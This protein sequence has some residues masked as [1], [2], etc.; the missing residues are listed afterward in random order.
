MCNKKK[1][2]EEVE[3]R[4]QSSEANMYDREML[5][6]VE[7]WV[8]DPFYSKTRETKYFKIV[9]IYWIVKAMVGQALHKS[10]REQVDLLHAIHILEGKFELFCHS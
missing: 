1:V 3:E 10:R 6:E 7:D 2:V 9:E 4:V 8:E 5:E